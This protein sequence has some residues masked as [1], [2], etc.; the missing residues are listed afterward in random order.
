MLLIILLQ[1]KRQ[2]RMQ[3]HKHTIYPSDTAPP[4]APTIAQCPSTPNGIHPIQCPP[5][6]LISG[7]RIFI[8]RWCASRIE[9]TLYMCHDELN[10][11]RTD[12]KWCKCEH[13]THGWMI[14]KLFNTEA[15]RDIVK[16]LQKQREDVECEEESGNW[17]KLWQ[18]WELAIHATLT[19]FYIV[20][21]CWLNVK[22]MYRPGWY[23]FSCGAIWM[24]IGVISE[25]MFKLLDGRVSVRM[26]FDKHVEWQKAH[27]LAHNQLID[28]N[29]I[30]WYY[31]IL[32]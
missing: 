7:I 14:E 26:V 17:W 10:A 2:N 11:W 9:H 25:C 32:L 20:S 16:R 30:F 19:C 6:P 1:M 5:N 27:M 8:L 21:L 18:S 13:R 15:T 3:T 4:N 24:H 22:C 23:Y 29:N 12:A 28:I 31:F